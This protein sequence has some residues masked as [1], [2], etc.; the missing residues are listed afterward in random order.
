MYAK[1]LS[2]SNFKLLIMIPRTIALALLLGLF[3]TI[4]AQEQLGIRLSGYGGINSTLLNPAYHATTPLRW[5][6]NLAEGAAHFWN[7]YAYMQETSLLSLWQQRDNLDFI[8]APDLPRGEQPQANTIV[9]DFNRD[10]RSRSTLALGSL[11]GPS[12]YF[13]IGE[14]H[15]IGLITRLR[16]MGTAR[17]VD[18][19]FSY[20]NYYP[21]PFFS[22]FEVAPFS[23]AIGAW[24]EVGL[25]YAYL[26]ETGSGQIAIGATVKA[27]QAYEGSYWQNASAFR[28]QKLPNDSLSGSPVDFRYGLTSSNLNAESFLP[29]RNGGGIGLDLGL[30]L[31]ID[32]DADAPYLWKLGVSLIDLGRINFNRNAKKYQVRTSSQTIIGTDAYRSFIS[33]EQSEDYLD[34]FSSQALG[35]STAALVGQSFGFWLPAALSL[36]VDHALGGPVFIGAALIQGL[37]LNPGLRRGSLLAI[38]PRLESRWLEAALPVSLY[39]WQSLRVGLAVRLAFLTIGTDHLGSIFRKSD[40]RGSDFYLALKVNPFS[41]AEPPSRGW[42]GGGNKRT[43]VGNGNKGRVKCYEF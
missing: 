12:F 8:A 30:T 28:L 6:I 13:S 19:Q 4:S 31:T 7:N 34:F 25:N 2:I 36:Q 37:P 32:G 10:Q 41:K 17:G 9:I 42:Q 15:R 14:Q 5:D 22:E 3:S 11:L 38:S 16:V 23:S 29:E 33:L 26:A 27:L 24:S 20:Y 18:N 1:A 21:R 35:D 40:L 43:R 39:D